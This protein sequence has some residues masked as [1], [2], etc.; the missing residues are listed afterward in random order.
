VRCSCWTK[1]R[2]PEFTRRLCGPQPRGGTPGHHVRRSGPYAGHHVAQT[3]AFPG[4]HVAQTGR[5]PG[6]TWPQTRALPG[7]HVAQ[8][9]ALPGHHVAQTRALPGHHV[10]QTRALPGHHV[11]QTRSATCAY[12]LESNSRFVRL[13]KLASIF[14]LVR[15]VTYA[16]LFIGFVP[17]YLP[18]RFLSWSGIVTPATTGAPCAGIKISIF[19]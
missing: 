1:W 11:A 19:E 18:V 2:D 4:H 3:R 13:D 16:A 7:H 12:I 14:V 8:T 15:A 5:Y 17:V 9:R 6:T 10:A